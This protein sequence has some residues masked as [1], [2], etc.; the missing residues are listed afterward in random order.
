MNASEQAHSHQPLAW[1]ISA[2]ALAV[3]TALGM[4]F[5]LSAAHA[6]ESTNAIAAEEDAT[7]ALVAQADVSSYDAQLSFSDAGITELQSGTGYSIDGT[8]LKIEAAGTYVVTGSCAEGAI[9]VAKGISDVVL[10]LDDLTLASSS[11]APIVVKKGSTATI[12]LE[13][14]S[15]L[16][17]NEDPANETSTDATVA[18]AFEGACIKVKSGSSV[19][20]CGDGTLNVV[21]NAKNGIKGGS[22]STLTFNATGSINVSGNYSGSATSAGAVNNGIAADGSLV[23]NSGTF[24]IDAAN[25]GI[26]S[27]P[28]A[29]DADSVGSITI[30]G[31]TF[32]IDVD[33]DGI[34]ADASLTITAGDFDIKTY[35]G[36][37]TWNDSLADSMSCKGLKASGDREGIEN[38]ITITGGT[39]VLD[40]GDDAVHSD[41]YAE[42]SGGTFTIAS[43]DDGMHADTTLLLGS[44]NGGDRDPDVTINNSYEGLEGGTVTMY[45]GRYYVVASDDGVNAAGG[46]SSGT[47]G[48]QPG[49][50][51]FNPGGGGPGGNPGGWGGFRPMS[52]EEEQAASASDYNIF[53]YG[54]DLYVNCSGDGLDSNGGLYLYGGTQAVFSQ[55]TRGDNS[56][57][58]ADGTVLI[59]GATV[60]TAG[61]TGMDGSA[62]SSWFGSG[63]KYSAST[64][65]YS[66]GQVLNATAGNTV[67]LSYKLPKAVNYTM[68][69]WPS[70]S[71]SSTPTLAK[72][73]S[74]TACKGGSWSHTWDSG[75][76]SDG[77]TTY[78]CS[79]CGATETQAVA[80]A[81]TVAACSHEAQHE[82]GESTQEDEGYAVTFSADAGVKQIDVYYTQDYATASETDVATAV[83][84]DGDTGNPDSTGSG[85]VNFLVQLKDGYTISSVTATEGAYKNIK[86]QGNGIYRITKITGDI[87]I[88]VATEGGS[89]EGGETEGEG[90]EDSTEGG[91]DSGATG[92]E[93]TTEGGTAEG[94]GGDEGAAEGGSDSGS[95]SGEQ[96]STEGGS[97]EGSTEG[98]ASEGD[99]TESGTTE[100]GAT[101]GGSADAGSADAVEESDTTAQKAENTATITKVV[102]TVKAKAVATAKKTVKSITVKNAQGTVTYKKVSGSKYLKVNKRTGKITVKKG[103]P[104]GTYTVKVKVKVSGNDSY[105]SLTKVIK[106]KIKVE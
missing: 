104:A 24:D 105:E 20:F 27:V 63:Q 22:T 50:D 44:E 60:F 68:A 45:S 61:T 74:V 33:G 106:V 72:A 81:A 87:T 88:T 5:P 4:S 10:V 11:T 95:E 23:I 65:S 71:Y 40:C 101:E 59:D 98:G 80:T 69:S 18:D 2:A 21:A 54:G 67:V 30:N 3:V 47:D 66:A 19:T 31:G 51:G 16:T 99:T 26:K 79:T 8:T 85:Q 14:T 77:V 12:H 42:V 36:Y 9:E 89:A 38:T 90:D 35:K 70:S 97:T 62:Q 83:S 102:K 78:T 46:S 75:T 56:A 103:T 64:T 41:A 53:I 84:R 7:V 52:E 25:D 73:S 57:I 48:G 100:S 76:T 96:G 55:A 28:D 17:D 94:D 37:G 92:D 91:S 58:D 15:T 34:Q 82:E 43:G 93:G 1:R 32:D 39:F 49:G 13:G 29:D 86:D 6:L